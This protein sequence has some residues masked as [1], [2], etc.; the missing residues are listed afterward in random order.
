MFRLM[1][2]LLV[3]GLLA[4]PALAQ[5]QEVKPR[6]AIPQ[7]K[8]KRPKNDGDRAREAV[9]GYYGALIKGEF[10]SAG[11]FVHPEFVKPMRARFSGDLAKATGPQ[12]NATLKKLAVGSE[13]ELASL[14]DAKFFSRFVSSSYG[15]GLQ[16]MANPALKVKVKPLRERCRTDRPFCTVELELT[17]AGANGEEVRE[18]K[19][20]A[21][22]KDG[23]WLVGEPDP[24]NKKKR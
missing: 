5:L 15:A 4:G 17:S 14:T 21:S 12:K 24:A 1:C 23:V 6:K 19:V 16:Q 7:K 8:R 13:A 10:A 18:M 2:T 9:L 20:T 3:T 22:K 11:S